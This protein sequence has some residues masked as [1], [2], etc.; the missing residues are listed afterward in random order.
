M[1]VSR[2]GG[3]WE[4][5][6][7]PREALA[8]ATRDGAACLGRDDEIGSLE[9]GKRAD[10]ALF[11]VSGLSFAGADSDPVAALTFCAPQRVRDLFVEGRRVVEDGHLTG[12]DEESLAADGHRVAGRIMESR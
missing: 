6:L 12:V 11:D 2:A 4:T 3:D 7:G 5:A 1:L 9:P 8:R 10:V